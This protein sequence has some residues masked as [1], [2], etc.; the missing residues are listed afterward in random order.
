MV[1]AEDMSEAI[2]KIGSV[3]QQ[4]GMSMNKLNAITATLTGATGLSGSEIGTATKTMLSRIFRVGEEADSGETEDALNKVGIA[5]RK[6]ATEFRNAEDIIDELAV[7]W[8][9]LNNVQQISLAQQIGG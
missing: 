5:V 4:T 8:K 3:A 9:T 2:G 6:S 7:K 1:S